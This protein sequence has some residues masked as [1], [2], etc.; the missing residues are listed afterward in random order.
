VTL[1]DEL[2]NQ[3]FEELRKVYELK[4]FIDVTTADEKIKRIRKTK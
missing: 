4:A 1:I 2:S 3:F